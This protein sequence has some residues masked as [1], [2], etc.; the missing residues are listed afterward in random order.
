MVGRECFSTHPKV[1]HIGMGRG[2][3]GSLNSVDSPIT[4]QLQV[5]MRRS[6]IDPCVSSTD[7]RGAPKL[8]MRTP[9][10][11][12]TVSAPRSRF[13]FRGPEDTIPHQCH[14]GVSPGLDDGMMK[15]A[16]LYPQ[17]ASTPATIATSPSANDHTL[18]YSYMITEY[19]RA[20]PSRN[21]TVLCGCTLSMPETPVLELGVLI[22]PLADLPW[23]LVSSGR[24]VP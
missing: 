7:L 9:I 13:T 6:L 21:C 22:L 24:L 5:A 10:S 17:S 2:L 4:W 14:S 23:S 20:L 16:W 12:A 3:G 15:S 18:H 11:R 8:R 19:E 1:P